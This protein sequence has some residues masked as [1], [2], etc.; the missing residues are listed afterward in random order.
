MKLPLT[1]QEIW[2]IFQVEETEKV[3][4]FFSKTYGAVN[5]FCYFHVKENKNSTVPRGYN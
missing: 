4:K 1:S 5:D 3:A 2:W